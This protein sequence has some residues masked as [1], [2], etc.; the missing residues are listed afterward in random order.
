MRTIGINSKTTEYS[1]ATTS[2]AML[3]CRMYSILCCGP[4]RYDYILCIKKKPINN[5]TRL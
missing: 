5:R 4:G 2:I 3:R 1:V